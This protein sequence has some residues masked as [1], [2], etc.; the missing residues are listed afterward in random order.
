MQL[1]DFRNKIECISLASISSLVKCLRVRPEPT[2]EWSTWDKHSSLL[3]KFVN[4]DRK[5]FYNIGPWVFK[6]EMTTNLFFNFNNSKRTTLKL[7]GF[8]SQN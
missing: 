6:N 2:L 1:K 4:Y 5:K 3:R 7:K 8:H